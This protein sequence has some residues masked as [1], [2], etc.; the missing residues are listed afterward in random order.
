VPPGGF[1]PPLTRFRKP[2]LYPLSYGSGRSTL[3]GSRR[4]G[5][6]ARRGVVERGALQ[7][8]AVP[9]QRAD[10]GP[11]P[12][13]ARSPGGGSTST[14]PRPPGP[15]QGR[16]PGPQ[17]RLHRQC[18]GEPEVGDLL[19]HRVAHPPV[20]AERDRHGGP[21]RG[22]DQDGGDRAVAFAPSR[23]AALTR[24]RVHRTSLNRC[25]F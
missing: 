2:T 21:D 16:R 1:E 9:A 22:G 3:S 14:P 10:A 4:P 24:H 18:A 12:M 25:L 15:P 19:A 5:P 8:A 6:P 7:D 13:S 17:P 11:T 23:C 20:H